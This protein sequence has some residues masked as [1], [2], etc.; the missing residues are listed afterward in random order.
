M[1]G[2]TADTD[3]LTETHSGAVVVFGDTAIHGG[4]PAYMSPEALDGVAAARPALDLWALGVVLFESITGRRPFGGAT[5]D[6]I[7]TAARGGLQQPASALNAA[8]PSDVDRYLLRVLHVQ[9]T[10]RPT[11]AREVHDDLERLRVALHSTTLRQFVLSVS[12]LEEV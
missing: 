5:R 3:T 2:T 4:T 9:P 12:P 1:V 8:V 7:K 11:G 6:D 10:Q